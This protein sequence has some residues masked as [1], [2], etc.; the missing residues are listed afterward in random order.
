MQSSRCNLHKKKKSKY[1]VILC[2]KTHPINDFN[3]VMLISINISL[4]SF[5]QSCNDNDML[6][7]L[8]RR[9]SDFLLFISFLLLS[10]FLFCVKGKYLLSFDK[11][12]PKRK[13]DVDTRDLSQ[14]RLALYSR[15]RVNKLVDQTVSTRVYASRMEKS[16]KRNIWFS[17]AR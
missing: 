16:D 12:A 7:F 11:K 1:I 14:T 9:V 3:S 4:L 8:S 10:F 13:R 17:R 6:R 2:W 15:N 5:R